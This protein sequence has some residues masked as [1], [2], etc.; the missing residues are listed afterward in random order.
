MKG[1]HLAVAVI[2]AVVIG[3]LAGVKFPKTGAMILSKAGM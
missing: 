3:Y 1:W 2:V